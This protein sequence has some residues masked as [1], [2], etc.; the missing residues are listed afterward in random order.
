PL[1][2]GRV[3]AVT[4]R[5]DFRLGTRR[6][7]GPWCRRRITRP[8]ADRIGRVWGVSLPGGPADDRLGRASDLILVERHHG[9]VEVVSEEGICAEAKESTVPDRLGTV[10][11]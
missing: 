6:V 2:E 9:R 3:V 8:V 11:D 1:T 7:G 5:A 4:A 10:E